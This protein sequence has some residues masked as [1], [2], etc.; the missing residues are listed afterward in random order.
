LDQFLESPATRIDVV[1]RFPEEKRIARSATVVGG[2]QDRIPGPETEVEFVCELFPSR[3]LDAF[4]PG[5][6]PRWKVEELEDR[7]TRH[8]GWHADTLAAEAADEQ[9]VEI[10][11]ADMGNDPGGDTAPSAASGDLDEIRPPIG[12]AVL[13]MAETV[14]EAHGIDHRAS[15][16]AKPRQ[17]LRF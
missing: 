14:L 10:D 8:W 2:L 13:S 15:D 1:A 5:D 11:A 17:H 6:P 4:D 9:R 16:I 3:L 12:D 7:R